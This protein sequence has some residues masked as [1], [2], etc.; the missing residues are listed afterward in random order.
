MQRIRDENRQEFGRRKRKSDNGDDMR[1]TN[2]R[3]QLKNVPLLTG[4]IRFYAQSDDEKTLLFNKIDQA[5]LLLDDR[6]SNTSNSKFLHEVSD[7]YIH[8]HALPSKKRQC[9]RFGQHS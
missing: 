3:R 1:I 4:N 6:V 5:K 7:F 2:K 9:G 8:Q